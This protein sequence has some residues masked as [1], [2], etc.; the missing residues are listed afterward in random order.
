MAF[1]QEWLTDSRLQR[2]RLLDVYAPAL[3]ERQREALRLHL[4]ED[5]SVTEL[6]QALT[7]SRA[8]AHDLLRRG[9]LRM[10]EMESQIGL[11]RRLE[12]AEQKRLALEVKVGRLELQL[13]RL[14]G[15]G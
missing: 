2:Q 13:Q 3:T 6:A 10:E 7:I 14:G 8:A 1:T 5:W 15:R 4:E 12:A 9:L 11:C